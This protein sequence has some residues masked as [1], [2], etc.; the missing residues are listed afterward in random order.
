MQ[1]DHAAPTYP[2]SRVATAAR[3]ALISSAIVSLVFSAIA[4][5]VSGNPLQA[6]WIWLIAWGA[7]FLLT[8]PFTWLFTV[9]YRWVKAD[10]GFELFVVSVIGMIPSALVAFA[11][12]SPLRFPYI[13]D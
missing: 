2:R 8:L 3:A 5:V 4:G 10:P 6:P 13:Y 9:L 1:T 7:T 11:L 12:L